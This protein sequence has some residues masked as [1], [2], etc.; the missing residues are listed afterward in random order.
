MFLAPDGETPA[1][2]GNHSTVTDS[3]TGYINWGADP[4]GS[5]D[6]GW[7]GTDHIFSMMEFHVANWVDAQPDK[8]LRIQVIS[9][10][11]T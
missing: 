7:W 9:E 10:L 1:Y 4:D 6:G 5:V 8:L 2:L 11:L 3:G